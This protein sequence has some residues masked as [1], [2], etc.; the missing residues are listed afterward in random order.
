MEQLNRRRSQTH[1]KPYTCPRCGY[2]TLRKTHIREHF[3]K[4]KPCPAQKQKLQLT[5]KIKDDVLANRVYLDPQ[6]TS[7]TTNQ[8]IN[9]TI[10]IQ[11]Y[12]QNM[13]VVDKI[14]HMTTYKNKELTGF[15]DHVESKY[16]DKVTEIENGLIPQKLRSS[17]FMDIIG[18]TTKQSTASIENFNVFY[19][20]KRKSIK[21]YDE[22]KWEDHL[23]EKGLGYIVTMLCDYYLHTYE[24]YL[25]KKMWE[26]D[27]GVGNHRPTD[28]KECEA[29]LKEFYAFIA[30]FDVDPFVKGKFDKQVVNEALDGSDLCDKYASMYDDIS[31]N[32]TRN[33]IKDKQKEALKVIRLNTETTIEE[34]NKEV[35]MLFRMDET[36]KKLLLNG[37]QNGVQ[38]VDE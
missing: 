29:S 25:I 9:Q 5:E 38:I 21:V 3:Q 30:V 35:T 27:N 37:A 8:I 32:L 6:E 20:A 2:E 7:P 34:L 16:L 31:G 19:D 10:Y 26:C 18:S 17:D 33:V 1:M 24:C 4:K 23:Q 15:Q 36:F 11:N 28:Y 12:V 13:N 14:R 22:D